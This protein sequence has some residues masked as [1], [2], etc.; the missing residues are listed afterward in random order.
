M[1]RP[2]HDQLLTSAVRFLI[3]GEE[4]EAATVLRSCSLNLEEDW[5]DAGFGEGFTV[6]FVTL[7]GPRAAYEILCEE[8]HPITEGVRRALQALLS[9]Q[10]VYLSARAEMIDIDLGNGTHSGIKNLIFAADGPKPEIVISDSITNEIRIVRN[11]KYCLVYDRAILSH[12]L[13][14]TELV[15]WWS[16]RANASCLEEAEIDFHARLCKSLSDGPETMMFNT[17]FEQFRHVLG[18][19]LPALIP[20]VYLHYDPYTIRQ[21]RG[22]KRLPRQRMDFLMLLPHDNRVVI[23]IDGKH[24]YS[25]RNGQASPEL[26]AEMVAEDRRLKLTGYDVYRFGGYEFVH[27]EK[28]SDI[29]R[30]FF[31]RVFERYSV[32]D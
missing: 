13:L 3:D 24:H 14:W 9:T 7:T 31:S 19:S 29:I 22:V 23:E 16:E 26:Y 1:Q 27:P 12:G 17:Y 10:E 21:L 28:A 32:A 15:E 8:E 25:L 11:E 20:Q 5:Y 6:W 2:T 18:K 30:A 4:E